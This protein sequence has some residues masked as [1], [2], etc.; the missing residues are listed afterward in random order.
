MTK[1]EAW[2][3]TLGIVMVVNRRARIGCSCGRNRAASQK[4]S[5]IP[6]MLTETPRKMKVIQLTTMSVSSFW[7]VPVHFSRVSKSWLELSPP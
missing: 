5:A 7:R 6:K 2:I 1:L 4:G 3:I